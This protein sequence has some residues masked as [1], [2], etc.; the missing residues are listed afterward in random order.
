MR[1]SAAPPVDEEWVRLEVDD[2]LRA[3]FARQVAHLSPWGSV[4]LDRAG[5]VWVI[6]DRRVDGEAA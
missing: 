6:V 3:V 1:A 2:D 5:Y 4:S